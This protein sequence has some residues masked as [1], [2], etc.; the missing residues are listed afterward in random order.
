MGTDDDDDD[1]DRQ[2]TMP[3]L[4]SRPQLPQHL[5]YVRLFENVWTDCIQ[6]GHKIQTWQKFRLNLLTNKL[7]FI[8]N[9]NTTS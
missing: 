2:M 5:L 8:A 3:I 9:K 6:I 1:Y 4:H 7:K